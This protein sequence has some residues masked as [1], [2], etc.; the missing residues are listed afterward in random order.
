MRY[1]SLFNKVNTVIDK[2]DRYMLTVLSVSQLLEVLFICRIRYKNHFSISKAY[3]KAMYDVMQRHEVSYQTIAHL[4][5]KRI[6]LRR[7]AEFHR[8]LDKWIGL[9]DSEPLKNVIILSTPDTEHIRITEFF[10]N[11][12]NY[13]SPHETASGR[14]KFLIFNISEEVWRKLNL[15][16]ARQKMEVETLVHFEFEWWL[17]HHIGNKPAPIKKPIGEFSLTGNR[18]CKFKSWPDLLVEICKLLY[19]RF[20]DTFEDKV[21]GLT[22]QTRPHRRYFSNRKWELVKGQGR[23]IPGIKPKLY[24]HTKLNAEATKSRCRIILNHFDIK[25][26]D[27]HVIT[28]KDLYFI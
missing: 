21:L 1:Y 14:D 24:V 2:S 8:L 10:Q 12:D 13:T 20:P 7:I 19:K 22:S 5:T 6:K 17:N 4:C 9:G 27:F 18:P 23:E 26:D 28:Y 15:S 16:A 25:S 3:R 11:P